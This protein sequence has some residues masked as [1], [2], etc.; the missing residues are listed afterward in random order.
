MKRSDAMKMVV[1]ALTMAV[2]TSAFAQSGTPIQLP[3]TPYVKF[4]ESLADVGGYKPIANPNNEFTIPATSS[5]FGQC[6]NITM[7]WDFKFYDDD[8]TTVSACSHGAIAMTSGA[9]LTTA[10]WA[11]GGSD[12]FAADVDGWIA[13]WWGTVYLNGSIGGSFGWEIGGTAPSRYLAMEY[14]NMTDQSS[15][16]S[17]CRYELQMQVRLF[18]GLAGKI[19]I[20]WSFVDTQSQSGGFA[21]STSGMESL[22]GDQVIEFLDPP[23]SPNHNWPDLA[24]F[25]GDDGKRVTLVQDPG[26]DLAA[27]AVNAPDFAPL[28]APYN[29]AV[30]IANL[31]VNTLGP[32]DVAIEVSESITF[33]ESIAAVTQI[34]SNSV[35]LPQ[36][37]T[38]TITVPG[39]APVELGERR[40]YTRACVDA[41]DDVAEVNE[42]NNCTITE[43][44]TRFLPSRPDVTI[45]RVRIPVRNATPG[46]T[47][48]VTITIS[49]IG[50]EPVTD[51]PI[52]VVLSGNP[53]ISPQDSVLGTT[54]AITMTPNEIGTVVEVDVDIPSI[55]NSGN[56]FV[57][58]FADIDNT[59]EESDESNN[60][61]SVDFELSIAGGELSVITPRLPNPLVGETYRALLTAVGG[62]GTYLW[63]IPGKTQDPV[64]LTFDLDNPG[65]ELAPGEGEIFGV[66][67]TPGPQTLTVE[68]ESRDASGNTISTTKTF[69]APLDCVDPDEPLTI[70]TRSVPEGVI[71]QEYTFGLIVTG[72]ASA[73]PSNLS[74]SANNL[75]MGLEVTPTGIIAGTPVMAGEQVATVS[76]DDGTGTD[77]GMDMRQLSFT[78]RPNPNLLIVAEALEPAVLGEAY[79]DQIEAVGGVGQIVFSQDGGT[80]PRGLVL[81]PD[82]TITGIPDQI[83]SFRFTVRAQDNP[84]TGLRAEDRNQ[85]TINVI[86]AQDNFKVV[87]ETLPPVVL[88]QGY[89]QTVSAVGG[90]APLVWELVGNLPDGLDWVQTEGSQELTISGNATTID[91]RNIVVRATDALNRVAEKVLVVTVVEPGDEIPSCPNPFFEECDGFGSSGDSGCA[92]LQPSDA[93]TLG[94]LVLVFGLMAAIRRRRR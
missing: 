30:S 34:G 92:S 69:D 10:N 36:Y 61:R 62:D 89:T 22:G 19:E 29:V 60:G 32:F 43:T 40:Y 80:M 5:P 47:I 82:G 42:D 79:S 2:S 23:N 86:D 64:S 85:F 13:P 74:W 67:Q 87:T 25:A 81:N 53:A 72:G 68:V 46:Q 18:E 21:S 38:R 91:T 44:Q 1:P 6:A 12:Q 59:F 31:N 49:N 41:N 17:C 3:G 93:G 70:V 7:P 55:I 52:A 73:T 75:P 63:N 45:D 33:D 27:L 57:G 4:E 88:E 26:I 83:G 77:D 16:F 76:V 51:M 66:C 11:P 78:I 24:R 48:P 39:T 20:D 35:T 84:G 9:R 37:Q 58:A 28:G 54:P 15:T 50:S 71:G 8:V 90:V 56:Y 94:G 14:V 65:L